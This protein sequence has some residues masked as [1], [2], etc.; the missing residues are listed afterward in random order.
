MLQI[1]EDE[2][3]SSKVSACRTLLFSFHLE[4]LISLGSISLVKI[5]SFPVNSVLFYTDSGYYV[6]KSLC[7]Q[8]TKT[9]L[10]IPTSRIVIDDELETAAIEVIAMTEKM[11]SS[12]LVIEKLRHEATLLLSSAEEKHKKRAHMNDKREAL[13]QV[14]AT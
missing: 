5:I 7:A 13:K 10:V 4:E 6:K 2:D 9:G 11:A 14:I 8:L 3:C 1:S 12:M